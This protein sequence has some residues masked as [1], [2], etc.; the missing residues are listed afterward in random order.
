MRTHRTTLALVGWPADK[1]PTETQRVNY[2]RQAV[3]ALAT[4]LRKTT[5]RLDW[6]TFDVEFRP[7]E[8]HAESKGAPP[9]DFPFVIAIH[10]SPEECAFNGSCG[11]SGDQNAMDGYSIHTTWTLDESVMDPQRWL[12]MT[13]IPRHE[14]G[15]L[16]GLAVGEL[17]DLHAQDVTGVEPLLHCDM[18][19]ASDPF[20]L[21]HPDWLRDPVVRNDGDTFCPMNVA[22]L[23][24]Q[25]SYLN[26]PPLTTTLKIKLSG[27]EPGE[28]KITLWRNNSKTGDDGYPVDHQELLAV[29]DFDLE[30]WIN[31]IP[32]LPLLLPGESPETIFTLD[33]FLLKI[34]GPGVSY[35]TWFSPWEFLE[36]GDG[37]SDTAEMVIDFQQAGP[38]AV[39]PAVPAQEVVLKNWTAVGGGFCF[40][41]TGLE[42]GVRHV[43]ESMN[44][45]AD[46][47]WSGVWHEVD[48][49]T[50]SGW[51]HVLDY[52]REQP[53]ASGRSG[54]LFRVRRVG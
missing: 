25:W 46:G 20:W 50:A 37:P 26:P 39:P 36:G 11:F 13:R 17:Y 9:D 40:G 5:R 3:L 4:S 43:V 6:A 45:N 19:D 35:A 22:I 30:T 51:S 49:F 16:C 24:G 7:A 47:Y 10:Y 31:G 52:E 21:R 33:M 1:L 27:L 41:V 34:T 2:M 48:R 42:D 28:K 53:N 44:V 54:E 8:W 32:V 23:S 29:I 14:F 18:R 12:E 38:P 15:H